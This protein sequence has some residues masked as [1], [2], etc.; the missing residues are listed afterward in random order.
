MAYS[1]VIPPSQLDHAPHQPTRERLS[2]SEDFVIF[3]IWKQLEYLVHWKGYTKK[4]AS[5][6]PAHHLANAVETVAK[7]TKKVN[8]NQVVEINDQL[9]A[10]VEL[11]QRHKLTCNVQTAVDA[12][13]LE[14]DTVNGLRM[15]ELYGQEREDVLKSQAVP[16][17]RMNPEPKPV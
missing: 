14:F 5:W 8:I 11:M 13:N 4:D 2:K 16:R 17:L 10:V 15:V 3:V 12:Y 1:T 6:E 9:I 7:Y